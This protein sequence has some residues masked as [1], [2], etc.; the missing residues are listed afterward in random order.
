MLVDI[1][2][3]HAGGPGAG[4]FQGDGEAG[5]AGEIAAGGDGQ[6]DRRAGEAIKRP[7]RDDQHRPRA[8]LL[9]AGRRVQGHEINVAALHYKSSLPVGRPS[10]HCRSS[11]LTAAEASHWA[12]SSSRV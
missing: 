9:M 12:S 4:S 8:L 2:A 5:R 1:A 7:G 11:S 10:S 3:H 6:D